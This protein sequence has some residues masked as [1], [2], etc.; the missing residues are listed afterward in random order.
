L[1]HS[2]S[3][4][5]AIGRILVYRSQPTVRADDADIDSIM[6]AEPTF[7]PPP[8]SKDE[9]NAR[10]FWACQERDLA[11]LESALAHG[12]DPNV[13]DQ[14]GQTPLHCASYRCQH[15]L[16]EPL[17]RAG[18]D[19]NAR[20]VVGRTPLHIAVEQNDEAMVFKLLKFG[21]HLVVANNFG[22]LPKDIAVICRDRY[23]KQSEHTD[24]PGERRR[25]ELEVKKYDWLIETLDEESERLH[26]EMLARV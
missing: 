3:S 8:K 11:L 6:P 26:K 21:A 23:R 22:E 4:S 20:D 5:T 7:V 18:G 15:H 12:A 16:I 25:C 9:A 19:I 24:D 17:V 2:V 1:G 14:T 13:T 10:L